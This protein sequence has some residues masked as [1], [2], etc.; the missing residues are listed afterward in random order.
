MN[1]IYFYKY[2]LF[3]NKLLPLSGCITISNGVLIGE[4]SEFFIFNQRYINEL[5]I[6]L[7]WSIKR[8]IFFLFLKKETGTFLFYF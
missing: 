8:D 6:F 2:L 4:V 3:D 5:I 7:N 1:Q